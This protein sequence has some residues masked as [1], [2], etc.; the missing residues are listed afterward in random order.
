MRLS[1]VT[2]IALAVLLTPAVGSIAHAQL[3]PAQKCEK[4][5]NIAAAKRAL[6]TARQR[7][8]GIGGKPS[9]YHLCTLEMADA[10]SRIETN[11]M[12]A[13]PTT[14]DAAA[15]DARVEAAFNPDQLPTITNPDCG[16]PVCIQPAFGP[17]VDD[18]YWTAATR[19]S[20][21]A[22]AYTLHFFG[23]SSLAIRGKD[24]TLY[25]RAVRGGRWW[26]RS[27]ARGRSRNQKS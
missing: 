16:D 5:K 22:A 1:A 17:V 6:C 14:G 23:D 8:R 3:T 7:V 25:V 9:L 11:A 26:A 21:H 15:L 12:G 4:L 20:A 27:G 10:F 13:C 24:D 19:T 2:R 18:F